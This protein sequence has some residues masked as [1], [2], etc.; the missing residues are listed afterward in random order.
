MYN[1]V[2][3]WERAFLGCNHGSV[4]TGDEASAETFKQL[5]GGGTVRDVA[6]GFLDQALPHPTRGDHGFHQAC[7]ITEGFGEGYAGALGGE[8]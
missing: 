7:Y 2:L 8:G 3:G 1:F 5:G 4:F 6:K